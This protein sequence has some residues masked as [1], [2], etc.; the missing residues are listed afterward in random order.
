MTADH[1]DYKSEKVLLNPFVYNPQ[2]WQ[3]WRIS[4]QINMLWYSITT[5]ILHRASETL[6]CFFCVQYCIC[7]TCCHL[8]TASGGQRSRST[9]S[10]FMDSNREWLSQSMSSFVLLYYSDT[11]EFSFQAGELSKV[12]LFYNLVQTTTALSLFP[13]SSPANFFFAILG[14]GAFCTIWFQLIVINKLFIV[15]YSL[16]YLYSWLYSWIHELI[17]YKL[18]IKLS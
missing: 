10:R 2:W 13:P 15:S 14:N 1:S 6:G 12:W 4:L 18:E 17:P 11:S 9:F 16:Y 3:L 8:F 7:I 5:A